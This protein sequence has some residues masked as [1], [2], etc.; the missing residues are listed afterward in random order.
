V[1]ERIP[2]DSAKWLVRQMAS[3]G[4]SPER[5]LRGTGLAESW[6]GDENALVTPSQ[7]L[8]IVANALAESG[9]PALGLNIGPKQNLGELGFWGY[10][11][12]SSPTLREAN[13]A[14]LQFW[15]LNGSLVTLSCHEERDYITWVIS[16]AFP[17][18]SQSLW[19]YSVEELLTTFHTAAG[20]LTN[21]EFQYAEIH[22]TYPDPG[23]SARYTE[24][25]RCPVHFGSDKDLFRVAAD[26]ADRPTFTGHPQMALVCQQQCREL[27]A[28]LRGCDELTGA[29]REIIVS[30]MGQ[31]P[32]LPE[33]AG[34][35]AMSPRTLRRRLHERGTTYQHI[36]DEIRIE[37][38][39]EYVASTGLSVDQIAGRIGFAEATTFRRAFKKWTGMNIKEF[40]RRRSDP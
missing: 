4:I 21:H 38:A 16:P 6:L 29:I 15:E 28:R 22:L 17:M 7:Y 34:R 20:F 26:G 40:K 8:R 27:Q 19:I 9:D 23:H 32:H 18:N 11:I 30:S 25:F 3:M 10:A 1:M 35:L 37:L 24:L 33:V 13:Q 5:V 12:I 36:L 39:K 2:S 14:A 31:I